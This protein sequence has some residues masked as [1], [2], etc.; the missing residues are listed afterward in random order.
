VQG[1]PSTAGDTARTYPTIRERRGAGGLWVLLLTAVFYFT[2]MDV[3]PGM[4]IHLSK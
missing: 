2:G 3:G 4:P 1:V